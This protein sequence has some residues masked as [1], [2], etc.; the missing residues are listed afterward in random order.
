MGTRFFFV[1]ATL[2]AFLV[3]TLVWVA[4]IVPVLGTAY[5]QPFQ[6]V[7][8]LAQAD[9]LLTSW[10]LAWGS[11]ALRTDPLGVYHANIFHPLP[12]TFAFSENLLAG[13]L[14][15]LP[16][17]VVWRNPTLDHNVLLIASCVLS[18]A[19]TA[20]LVRELGAA[21]PGA[22]LAGAIVAFAPLRF[23]TI[24]HVQGLSAHWMPF[25]LLAVHRCLRRGRGALAVAI[26]V[27]LVSL[28]S[29]Y[30]AY[31]FL[32]ALAVFVPAHWL[33]GG[34]AAPGGRARA[35]AGIAAAAAATALLLV[36]YLFARDM[37]AFGRDAGEAWFMAARISNYLGVVVDPLGYVQQRYAMNEAGTWLLGLGTLAFMV[38]GVAAGAPRGGRRTSTAYLI[39]GIALALVSMGPL[40]EWQMVTATRVPGPWNVFAAVVPGFGALRVPMR[41]STVALLAAGVPSD[42]ARAARARRM[43]RTAVLIG[44]LVVGVLESWRAPFT[45]FT[46]PWATFG[47]APVHRWLAAQPGREAVLEMPVG[48]F[49]WDAEWMVMSAAHWR[50]LV[51][52][53]SG[54][55]PTMSFFR[56]FMFAFPSPPTIRL[57]HDLGV[58]WVVLHPRR[59]HP[60]QGA[61][62][63][64]EPPPFP[65]F[66]DRVYR[67]DGSCVFEVKS[68]PP[69]APTPPDRPV[70]LADATLTTSS[71][72]HPAAAHDG[73]LETHWVE[74]VN[75]MTESWLQ[76]DLP[77][78]PTISRLVLQLGPHFG[79]YMRQWRIDT[80]LDGVTWQAAA[81][82]RNGTPPLVQ[83]RTDPARLTQELRLP[84]ATAAKHVRV[85]RPPS[86]NLLA[87]MDVWPNWTRWGMH[88]IQ[89]FEAAP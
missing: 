15:I 76:L 66:V 31:F 79:E 67:D 70:S 13:A 7:P 21:W 82:E 43:A 44:L 63:D 3:A 9:V 10:M 64:P 65:P 74:T 39:M 36:P 55:T 48:V 83:L 24:G 56:G 50:P 2:V 30:Y 58:R 27:L 62:C 60:A 87:S 85:V 6:K 57:L 25:A 35:I 26:T 41:A 18:G 52:G 11:H 73:R 86:D 1:G 80:S 49:A 71:G 46:V 59:M 22:W 53:Y 14:L 47:V 88:E 17:D 42:P 16:V 37:Y 38:V 19:G 20:F 78:A 51:N 45:I 5:L 40:I 61:L 4:P 28:S 32:L 81:V 72:E 8:A 29:V 34:A 33:L 89:V 12:W 69:P 77:A 75:P 23:G 68:A 54:F 84:I